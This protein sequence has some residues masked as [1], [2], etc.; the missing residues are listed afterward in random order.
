MSVITISRGSYSRGKEVAEKVAAELGY[1]CI[2]RDILLEASEEFNIPEIRLIRALHDAPSALERFTHGRER[3]VSYIRKALLQHIR[4][5]NIVYHGLA[6]HYF[7][8][9]LPNVLKIRIVSDIEER[10]QEEMRRENI[11]E[12]K[13]RYI[14]KKDDDERRKWGLRLYGIDTWDS[15][16]YDMVINI[17]NLSVEDAADLICRTVRKSHFETTPE[18]EKILD[19]ALLAAKVHA[20]LVK[21]FPK[22]IVTAN[23]GVV[24]I[25]DP[26]AP[27][28]IKRDASDKIKGIAENVDGVKEIIM[29]IHKRTDDHHTV[30]PFHNI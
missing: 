19:D 4:K 8:L 27:S 17:K 20:A 11:S 1:E 23:D 28:D 22:I 26:E 16:L 9:N 29:G 25:G 24:S 13:A 5:D 14:L 21:T 2:S 7:L 30:N 10:V 3:Y 15:K 18:S 12:E 6:G